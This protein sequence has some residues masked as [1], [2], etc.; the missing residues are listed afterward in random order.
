MRT[1][2]FKKYDKSLIIGFVD[3]WNV[4]NFE[5]SFWW[6]WHDNWLSL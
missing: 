4:P 3:F 1:Y 6:G 2:K 5:S